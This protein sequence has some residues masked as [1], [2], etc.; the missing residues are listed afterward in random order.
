M[1]SFKG[2]SPF[3]SNII[4]DIPAELIKQVQTMD[5][6]LAKCDWISEKLPENLHNLLRKNLKADDDV[7]NLFQRFELN[8]IFNIHELGKHDY[9]TILEKFHPHHYNAPGFANTIINTKVLAEFFK[10][11]GNKINKKAAY[12]ED[13]NGS[14]ELID[15][16][17]PDTL[18]ETDEWCK[19][20]EQEIV[21]IYRIIRRENR[22]EAP[23]FMQDVSDKYHNYITNIITKGSNNSKHEKDKDINKDNKGSSSSYTEV[24]NKNL[25]FKKYYESAF[26]ELDNLKWGQRK[27]LLSEIDFLT[28]HYNPL[29]R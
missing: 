10:E 16:T 8:T 23:K 20:E 17:F 18:A 5:E 19:L 22:K 6:Q 2:T 1:S 25:P 4:K 15:L 27:L 13:E 26:R 28:R 9:K 3:S 14:E 7:V 12:D 11:K 29:I 24:I 21:D